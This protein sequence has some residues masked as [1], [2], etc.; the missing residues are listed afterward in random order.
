MAWAY[1]GRDFLIER[2]WATKGIA[3]VSASNKRAV[4]PAKAETH[5]H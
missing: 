1:F 4:V 2:G 5:N 3:G